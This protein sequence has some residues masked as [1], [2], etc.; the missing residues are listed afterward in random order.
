VTLADRIAALE[1][2]LNALRQQQLD[3]LIAV[4]ASSVGPGVAFSARE[5]WAHRQ[6]TPALTAAFKELGIR[7]PWQLGKR[8]RRLCGRGLACIGHDKCGAIWIVS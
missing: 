6:V 7:S 8:L 1:T 5:L 2:E 3:A 4:I